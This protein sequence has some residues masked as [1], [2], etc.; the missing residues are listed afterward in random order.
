MATVA[1]SPLAGLSCLW[2]DG[3]E[4]PSLQSWIQW[5]TSFQHQMT[6]FL[7]LNPSIVLSDTHWIMLF[8]QALG[9]E[10]QRHFDA[11]NLMAKTSIVHVI[12]LF[13]ELWGIQ[14][15]VFSARY[16]FFKLQQRCGES[17]NDFIA[18]IHQATPECRYNTI[19]S[20]RFEEVMKIQCLIGGVT[21]DGAREKLLSQEEETL[22][23]EMACNLVRQRENLKSQ[24]S[25]F[26]PPQPVECVN[27]LSPRLSSEN[28]VRKFVCYRCGD[29]HTSPTQCPHTRTKCRNCGK[30]GHLARV[31]RSPR[32]QVSIK[33]LNSD[34]GECPDSQL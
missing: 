21:D 7:V 26:N 13:E 14:Q 33:S 17:V 15:S 19:P 27:K 8:R 5:K 2:P 23:W 22:S 9:S 11:M 10:G 29:Q 24:L 34:D 20:S 3:A 31:C 4:K 18:R 28:R 25:T 12:Q 16:Q 32:S 1:T 30:L 6:L